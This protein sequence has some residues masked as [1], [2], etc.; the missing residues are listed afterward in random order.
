MP[1][2]PD[3]GVP[4]SDAKNSLPDVDTAQPA[5]ELWYSTSRCQPR[6][7]PAA[8][9]AMLAEDMNLI[10][11]AELQYDSLS[12]TH[13]ERAVRYLIQRGLP[14]GSTAEGG[15]AAYRST[16]DPPL[17][18]YNDFL[19]LDVVPID[20]ENTG[21]ITIDVNGKGVVPVLRDD[22]QQLQ[23]GDWVVGIP[24][25]IGYWA[26]NFYVLR[27]VKSQIPQQ[28]LADIDAWIRTDGN[29]ITGDGT[30]NDPNKAFRTINGAW[31]MLTKKYLPSPFFTIHLRLGIPGLYE[32]GNLGPFPGKVALHGDIYTH[33]TYQI[34]MNL[35]GNYRYCLDLNGIPLY[36]EGVTFSANALLN[37]GDEAYNLRV[38][39]GAVVH[40]YNVAYAIGNANAQS[41]FIQVTYNSSLGMEGFVDMEAGG[42]NMACAFRAYRLATIYTYA[43]SKFAQFNVTNQN[44]SQGFVAIDA[45][46]TFALDSGVSMV[47]SGV[48]GLKY[49]ANANS[50]VQAAG[51]ILPG[52][53]PGVTTY[54]AQYVP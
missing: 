3:S 10:M 21:P 34:G 20:N 7:D 51:K 50:T 52:D 5:D 33:K 37:P 23:A 14:M 46:S 43:G 26:G 12:L 2:F 40:T 1:M 25:L 16:L 4:A 13:I 30:A 27:K 18:R 8:A 15:P 39:A 22:G 38:N 32:A 19:V 48:T 42:A 35:T 17:T 47:Y 11:K 6:F 44:Y 53:Q 31:R 49:N 28:L 24:Y 9:N 41:A 29:D 45:L 36:I 54:G